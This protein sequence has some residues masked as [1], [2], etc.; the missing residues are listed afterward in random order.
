MFLREERP[1]LDPGIC[2]ICEMAPETRYVDTL[3]NFEPDVFSALIG[4]KFVCE[5]CVTE[6]ARLIGFGDKEKIATELEQA[7]LRIRSLEEKAFRA[8]AVLDG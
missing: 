6:M 4:R 2:F 5:N 3:F 1:T 8:Q 7:Q